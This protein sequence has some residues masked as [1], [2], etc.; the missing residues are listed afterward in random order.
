MN[1]R[2]VGVRPNR[3]G[4]PG[5]ADD[6][7]RSVDAPTLGR[8][9][10]LVGLKAPTTWHV[11]SAISLVEITSIYV[12]KSFVNTLLVTLALYLAVRLLAIRELYIDG[13]GSVIAAFTVF[14]LVYLTL[15]LVSPSQQGATNLISIIVVFVVFLYFYHC[16]RND[17]RLG[18]IGASALVGGALCCILGSFRDGAKN[19]TN[20]I[21]LYLALLGG[22]AL[23]TTRKRPNLVAAGVF[24]LIGASSYRLDHR[25]GIVLAG[26]G[27][28]IYL[29]L[30]ALPSRLTKVVALATVLSIAVLVFFL[31]AGLAGFDIQHYN[32]LLV[33]WTGRTGSS[34]RQL[35]FP[36]IL[37]AVAPHQLVGLGTGTTFA[38]IYPFKIVSASNY[39]LQIYLQTGLMGLTSAVVLLLT[40]W[41]SARL[42]RRG[43]PLGCLLTASIAILIVHSATEVFLTQVNV[44][45]GV[46]AWAAIGF[47]LGL[48]RRLGTSQEGI[49]C[50]PASSVSG[51]AST[52]SRKATRY[53]RESRSTRFS[54]HTGASTGPSFAERLDRISNQRN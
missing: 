17:S 35:I 37:Q 49:Q 1:S 30:R 23:I 29:L 28:V 54:A 33:Q 52:G 53:S 50:G 4:R 42:P 36:V 43:D 44:K 15:T 8:A 2:S 20:G 12:G 51:R 25:A 34:G 19:S 38:D 13:I 40:L 24:V 47:G 48:H 27:I 10:E 6:A 21:V 18:A 45:L 22:L 9:S 46:A 16:G 41:R 7:R 14:A 39:Y 5:G 31:F 32:G 11:V 3:P 26:I